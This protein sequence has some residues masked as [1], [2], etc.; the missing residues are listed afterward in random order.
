MIID[1]IAFDQPWARIDGHTNS[2][3]RVVKLLRDGKDKKI[4]EIDGKIIRRLRSAAMLPLVLFE[5][6]HL[7]LLSG[8]PEQRRVYLDDLL[9][10]IQPDYGRL[11]REYKRTLAQRNSLLKLGSTKASVQIFA[12]NIRLSELAGRIV[13]ARSK[14][15][16]ELNDQ[17][18]ELYARLSHSEKQVVI[19]YLPMFAANEYETKMLTK[20]E[21]SMELDVLR[22][23]TATGP[24]REDF[25]IT[26]DGWRASDIASRGETRTAVLALKIL[27][28][29]ILE[30]S[31]DMKPI[32]LL[33]D[34]FSEL[35][36]SRRKLLTSYVE[37]YQSFI[38]TTD[39]D[40]VIQNFTETC[41]V[42][43]LSSGV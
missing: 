21:S 18:P 6:N 36:G 40:I 34:V 12:W 42:I 2:H 41:N 37:K 27:E 39:A 7:S 24:H 28:L 5:P 26:Y 13:R 11:R 43:P 38:T 19:E 14:L 8:S 16:Q 33:D 3:D 31:H 1:L 4:F 23:F 29:E 35:D 20:L 17:L 22:G 10:Q 9:E 15:A 32:L 25:E 30:K